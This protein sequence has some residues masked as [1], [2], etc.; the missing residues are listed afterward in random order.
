MRE[1]YSVIVLAVSRAFLW[2]S[3]A[4]F[5]PISPSEML[6]ERPERNAHARETLGTTKATVY[7][8][9]DQ[10]WKVLWTRTRTSITSRDKHR[11]AVCA[12]NGS[13]PFVSEQAL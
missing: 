9:I 11:G 8:G 5:R 10:S 7:G 2:T 12:V 4:D 3:S 1:G 6:E 13:Q